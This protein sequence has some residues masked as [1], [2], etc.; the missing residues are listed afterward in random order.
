MSQ[1]RNEA[2]SLPTVYVKRGC[3]GCD[4]AR[5]WLVANDVH[6]QEREIFRDPLTVTEIEDLLGDRPVRDVLSTRTKQF[7]ARGLNT[8]PH[9]EA[10][11]LRHMEMEPRLLRRPILQLGDTLVVG[12]DAERWSAVLLGNQR[13]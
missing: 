12:F 10:E 8:R 4:V 5:K 9:S 11:L 2:N 1:R 6:V 13:A 3:S 7:A